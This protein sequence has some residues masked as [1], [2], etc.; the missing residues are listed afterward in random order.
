MQNTIRWA[1]LRRSLFDR[2]LLV[3]GE[4]NWNIILGSL[5]ML[6]YDHYITAMVRALGWFIM[7]GSIV[8]FLVMGMRAREESDE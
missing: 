5:N 1:I 2:L 6:R 3:G 7:I 4:H 8:W